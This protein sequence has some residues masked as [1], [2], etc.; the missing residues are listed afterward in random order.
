MSGE[1]DLVVKRLWKEEIDRT[2]EFK[3]GYALGIALTEAKHQWI[4]C[5]DRLPELDIA[6]LV[7]CPFGQQ[8]AEL[9]DGWGDGDKQWQETWRGEQLRTDVTHWQAVPPPEKT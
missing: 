2:E 6:V 5:S 4:K 7:I 3:K 9:V 8:T 1:L